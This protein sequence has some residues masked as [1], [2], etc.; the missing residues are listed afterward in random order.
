MI[1][2]PG[3]GGTYRHLRSRVTGLLADSGQTSSTEGYAQ[4]KVTPRG[5]AVLLDFT[6]IRA[7][8]VPAFQAEGRRF[9]IPDGKKGWTA[10]NP[11]YHACMIKERDDALNGHLKPLIRL[12]KF[13]NIQ[14][15]GH[16]RSFHVELM[17]WRMWGASAPC[18]RIPMQ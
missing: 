1:I 10:T 18:L 11:P 6:I 3:Q 14:N 13:W 16:L 15:G 17:V 4:T 5:V 9:F 12:M 2:I 8:I 7:D